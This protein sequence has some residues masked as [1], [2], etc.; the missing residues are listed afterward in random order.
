M[1]NVFAKWRTGVVAM[2]LGVLVFS[3]CRKSNDDI[4]AQPAAGVMAFNLVSDKRGGVSIGL[5]GGLLTQVPI[6]YAG[7]TGT[8]FAVLPNSYTTQAFDGVGY[9]TLLASSSNT[10]LADKYYSVFVTGA[11]GVYGN[12]VTEDKYDSLSATNGQAYV[13]YI[14]AIPDSS[15]PRVTITANGSAVA[16]QAVHYQTVSSFIPVTPGDVAINVSNDGNIQTSRTISL[17]A[18]KAYTI[19]LIGVPGSTD[20]NAAVQIRYVENGTLKP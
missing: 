8:Y 3:S 7:F 15:N 9:G 12:V 17:A 19:L 5:S 2:V 18:Q 16:N 13:R 11:N 20:A 6:A 14:N 4:P 1:K 10:F